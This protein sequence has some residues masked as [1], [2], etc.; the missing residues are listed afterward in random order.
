MGPW[1]K[2][3]PRPKE[4]RFF[5]A[6][7][8]RLIGP[9]R[10][11]FKFNI[12]SD[13]EFTKVGKWPV[14]KFDLAK[15]CSS[16]ASLIKMSGRTPENKLE[17]ISSLTRLERLPIPL[18]SNPDK[19][20]TWRFSSLRFFSWKRLSVKLPD[21]PFSSK[22]RC[23]RELQFSKPFGTSP[24]NW[25]LEKLST[26]ILVD[27]VHI[28]LLLMDPTKALLLMSMIFMF[29]RLNNSSRSEPWRKSWEKFRTLNW[30]KPAKDPQIFPESSKLCKNTRAI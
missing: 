11:L 18:L 21:K 17:E 8:L 30:F 24:E 5:I 19:L 7:Q 20:L 10:E 25:L 4:I 16:L 2:F 14:N 9:L 22:E 15:N 26:W 6:E 1:N 12:W 27:I 28:P 29:G 13:G 23:C 3:K